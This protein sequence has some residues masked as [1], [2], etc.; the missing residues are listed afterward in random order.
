MKF[1]LSHRRILGVV[2]LI[3]IFNIA[4][5]SPAFGQDPK[6]QISNLDRFASKAA[7]SVDVTID[8]PLLKLAATFLSAKRSPDEAKIKELVSGLKGVYVRHFVFEKEGEFSESDVE[9]IRSQLRSSTWTKLVGVRSKKSMN[10]DV[11]MMYEGSTVKGLAVLASEPK[12]LTV[13]NIVGPIDL[14]KL[15]Q[16]EG[17]FGIPNLGLEKKEDK[18]EDK[19]N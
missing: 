18:K 7:E 11:F 12:E 10:V 19:K 8:E 14:E 5:A 1:I 4:A 2:V 16:L 13:V 15:M 3:L 9:A 6:L 17:Q